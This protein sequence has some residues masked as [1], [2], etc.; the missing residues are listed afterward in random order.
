MSGMF[1]AAGMPHYLKGP[2]GF[3]Q[4]EQAEAPRVV[5]QPSPQPV[6]QQDAPKIRIVPN[7]RDVARER[8][9]MPEVPVNPPEPKVQ[10]FQSLTDAG[11]FASPAAYADASVGA[12]AGTE[13]ETP[14]LRFG[15]VDNGLLVLSTLAGLKIDHLIAKR[16]GSPGYGPLVGA[17]VGNAIT[18]GV[19]AFSAGGIRPAA[20]VTA[21][22][23]L[24]VAPLAV[25]MYMKKP[26]KGKVALAVGMSTVLLLGFTFRKKIMSMLT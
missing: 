1:G 4:A 8:A 3:A 16:V 19:A 22:A 21:G 13:G 17:L 14:W 11:A 25:A 2:G 24:P 18:D 9:S 23:L 26:L 12:Y 15:L 6:A 5:Q 7:A 20:A 10:P